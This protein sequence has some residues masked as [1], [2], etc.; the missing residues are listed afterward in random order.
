MHKT[1][2]SRGQL[3]TLH[4]G[5]STCFE[6]FQAGTFML[7]SFIPHREPGQV[8]QEMAISTN[9]GASWHTTEIGNQP[10]SIIPFLIL[11][12]QLE[13]SDPP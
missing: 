13:N 4:G 8:T 9:S 2:A 3:S 12:G 6:R 1:N 10:K 7:N 11:V 5:F